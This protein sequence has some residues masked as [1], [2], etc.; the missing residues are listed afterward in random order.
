MGGFFVPDFLSAQGGP[1]VTDGPWKQVSCSLCGLRPVARVGSMT[2]RF[3]RKGNLLDWVGT[4]AGI[5]IRP[6]VTDDLIEARLSGWRAGV[7][8]TSAVARLQG[9]DLSYHEFVI[10]GHARDYAEQSGLRLEKQCAECGRRVYAYPVEPLR[11]PENCWDG[12]DVFLIEE[13]GVRVV[14]EPFRATVEKNHHTGIE[15]TP[16][17]EWRRWWIPQN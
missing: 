3:T 15:F 10:V 6:H 12:S 16:L 5:L 14:T 7:V 17:S 11:M 4:A 13:L 9:Q 8:T 2:V 1:T